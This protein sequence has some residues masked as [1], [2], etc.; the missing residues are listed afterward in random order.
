VFESAAWCWHVNAKTGVTSATFM[1]AWPTFAAEPRTIIIVA[2][3]ALLQRRITRHWPDRRQN[4]SQ[5]R[6]RGPERRDRQTCRNRAP[7]V[8]IEFMSCDI[9][10]DRAHLQWL[11]YI[12]NVVRQNPQCFFFARDVEWCSRR[13]PCN[14]RRAALIAPTMSWSVDRRTPLTRYGA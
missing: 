14:T 8:R 7:A 4:L 3:P 9:G 10:T 5:A 6:T 13:L 1:N 2:Q 12:A 11:M